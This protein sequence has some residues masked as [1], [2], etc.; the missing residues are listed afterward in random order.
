MTTWNSGYVSDIG[1]TYGYYNEL[2]PNNARL[3][4]LFAGYAPPSS[5]V[6]CELGYG[7]GLS[8]NVHAAASGSTWYGTD[9]NPS[10]AAFAQ[11]LAAASGADAHLTDEAFADFCSR[12]DLP[13]F[14]SIGL[15]G[16]WSWVSDENRAVIVDFIRRKLKVGGALYISYNTLPG[17]ATFAPMRHL[18]TEHAS[19]MGSPGKGVVSRVDGAL[20]FAQKLLDTNPLFARVNTGVVD[21]LKK[22]AEQDRHYLAHEYFNKDWHPMHFATM[23]QWLSPAK[24]SFVCSAHY[25]DHIE[26][27]NLT[28]EQ[29]AMLKEIPDPTFKESV[30]DFMVNQQFRRDYWIKG[31]R[32]I[33]ALEQAE[34]VLKHKVVLINNRADVLLKTTGA[35]GEATLSESIYAPIIELMSDH[36]VRSVGEI[37]ENLKDKTI[38]LPQVVQAVMVLIGAGHMASVQHEDQIKKGSKSTKK[39]NTSVIEHTQFSSDLLFLASPI[40]GAGVSVNRIQQLFLNSINKGVRSPQEWAQSA[41]LTLSSQNQRLLKDGKTMDAESDNL[42]EL[43]RQ[44]EEFIAKKLPILKALLVI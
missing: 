8:V 38:G 12:S 18:M 6:H 24:L 32:K 27:V 17:W 20:E 1:Y 31:A 43:Q 7:Q 25:L 44:A 10:Q 39:L 28:P 5:G 26:A 16:I 15:H 41:W 37:G 13:D 42:T 9:F 14:D 11:T 35:L 36:A 30:R 40:T 4:I 2:N 33:S 22:V 23:N 19:V 29:Q 3:A 34:L 21:R